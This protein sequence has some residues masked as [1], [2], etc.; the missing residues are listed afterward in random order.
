MGYVSVAMRDVLRQYVVNR[1]CDKVASMQWWSDYFKIKMTGCC[2]AETYIY[3]LER[4]CEIFVT[5][6]QGLPG[7]PSRLAV[8]V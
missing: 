8:S 4:L 3:R 1:C 7:V 6:M 2:E 5:P